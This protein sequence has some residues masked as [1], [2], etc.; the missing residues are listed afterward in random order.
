MG[1]RVEDEMLISFDVTSLFTNIPVDEAVQVIRDKLQGDEMLANR[2]TLSPDRVVELFEAC[3]RS[4]YFSYGG[5]VYEQREGAAMGSP[6]SA[7]VANPYMEFFEELALR[8]A[9]AKPRLWKRYMDDTCCIVKKGTVEG[10]LNYLNSVRA[11]IR[12]TVEVDKDGGLPF[13]TP[14]SRGENK[15]AWM[16]LSPGS[17]HTLTD[18]WTS[19]RTVHPMSRGN[20]S[21][22]DRR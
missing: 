17:P 22:G 12:F 2:T 7:A 16:S 3:L 18:T 19:D 6:V 11:S 14:C 1:L 10:L 9:S 4:T 8:S 13:S 15:A 5:D 21:I 20:W